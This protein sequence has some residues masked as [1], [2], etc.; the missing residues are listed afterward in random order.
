MEMTRAL[1][2]HNLSSEFP[3]AVKGDGVYLVD[4]AG[5]RYL[6]A[7]C[8]AAVSCLGHSNERVRSAI[9]DQAAQLAFAHTRF[10]SNEPMEQ[11]AED[12]VSDA[13]EGLTKV[14]FGCGGSEAIEAALKLTRQYFMEIGEP[15]RRHVIARRQGYHGATAGALS[16]TGN[17]ARRAQFEPLL[18]PVAHHISPCFAYRDRK[19][20]ETEAQYGLRVADEL[21][22]EILRLGPGTVAAFVA[23]TVVGSTLGCVPAVPG[24]F[25]RIRE[26]C[27]RHGVLLILDEVMC[28]MGRTGM[29]Y[30][31]E[32]EGITADFIAVAKGLSGGYLPLGAVLINDRIHK[33]IEAG[34]DVVMH[35][36]TYSGHPMSCAVALAVQQEVR[37]RNLLANVRLMGRTLRGALDDR[38]GNHPQVGDIRGRGLFLALELVADRETKEPFD[39]ALKLASRI[40]EAG[41]RNGLICYP[42]G[43]V[44][45]GRRGENVML[46]PPF[47]IDESHVREMVDKLGRTLDEVLPRS[48]RG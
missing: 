28:G 37:D 7:S 20:G 17:L 12:L 42:M 10:F 33:A 21:E 8:G 4:A 44:I 5:R 35:S 36:H 14:W 24:Y 48:S 26:I 27:D 3:I 43:G 29:R 16:A 40:L 11:L 39:P 47:I 15:R 46:A 22:A 18:L 30:A 9:T 6:D 38:F 31:C 45:D 19:E 13:P 41:M 2:R 25:K 34:S 23:E 32:E 1:Y